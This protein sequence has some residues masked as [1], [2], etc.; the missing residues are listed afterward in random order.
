MLS[1]ISVTKDPDTASRV[2]QLEQ[3]LFEAQ[4]APRRPGPDAGRPGQYAG[5]ARRNRALT[6]KL[7]GEQL[8]PGIDCHCNGTRRIP[9]A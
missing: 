3:T 9:T 1:E 2:S 8:V 7:T 4:E 5:A 6:G